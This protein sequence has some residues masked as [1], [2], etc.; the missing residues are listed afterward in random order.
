MTAD[1]ALGNWRNLK[2]I[3]IKLCS[4]SGPVQRVSMELCS[5]IENLFSLC[6][7]CAGVIRGEEPSTTHDGYRFGSIWTYRLERCTLF[8]ILSHCLAVTLF[9]LRMFAQAA[10]QRFKLY[11]SRKVFVRQ[12][13][14]LIG[15]QHSNLVAAAIVESPLLEKFHRSRIGCGARVNLLVCT[16]WLHGIPRQ[17][18]ADGYWSIRTVG[19]EVLQWANTVEDILTKDHLNVWIAVLAEGDRL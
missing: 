17:R 3:W 9:Q 8:K 7:V 11:R 18:W 12:R 14:F 13:T 16:I 1:T 15:P 4:R 2:R 6:R 5:D 10:F 19:F